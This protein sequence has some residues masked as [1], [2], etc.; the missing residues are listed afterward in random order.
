MARSTTASLKRIRSLSVDLAREL[1]RI[2]FEDAVS[3]S[4]ANAIVREAEMALTVLQP[5]KP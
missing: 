2:H 3:R 5:K 4:L 1:E